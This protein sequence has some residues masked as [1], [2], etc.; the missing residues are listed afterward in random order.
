[1]DYRDTGRLWDEN[2]E[3][4][5]RLSRLGYDI[6]RD[7]VNTPAFLDM[8]PDVAGL[9]GLDIGCGEG[10]NTR[11]IRRRGAKMFALDLSQNFI[12]HAV[13]EEK[14]RPLGIHY[15]RASGL[16]LPFREH[17][18]D[19]AV[20]TM[21]LMDIPRHEKVIAETYRALRPGA[22]LQFSIT[23][24]CFQT[25]RWKFVYDEAGNVSSVECGDYFFPPPDEIEEW[26]FRNIPPELAKG[27]GAFRVPAFRRTLSGWLNLLMKSGFLLEAFCE[28]YADE[29][30]VKRHPVLAVTRVIAFFLIIHCRKPARS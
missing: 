12:K 22:F 29:E 9:R 26:C 16:E 20:A 11:L 1:V 5:T 2:A 14:Q 13:D 23:H 4:W 15:L 17:S 6:F 8:L 18:F 19:F 3:A 21:S 28:P 10:H 27:F 7:H 30:S 25:P 24:P